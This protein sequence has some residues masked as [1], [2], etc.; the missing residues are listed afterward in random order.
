MTQT[1]VLQHGS[2][3]TSE[4]NSIRPFQVDIPE[5]ELI[6]LRR[7]ISATKWPERETVAECVWRSPSRVCA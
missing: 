4:Q 7:R 3:Q 1:A 2:A 6:E 5:P